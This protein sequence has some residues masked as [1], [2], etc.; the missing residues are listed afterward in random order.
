[1]TKA[2]AANRR[3]QAVTALATPGLATNPL[4]RACPKCEAQPWKP[5]RRWISGRICGEDIG[6]GYWRTLKQVHAER[7]Q[8]RRQR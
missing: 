5:C 2:R 8:Q 4:S 1:M 3:D 7:K 6:G